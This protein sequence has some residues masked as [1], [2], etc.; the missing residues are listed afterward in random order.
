MTDTISE[1]WAVELN[2]IDFAPYGQVIRLNGVSE[3][4]TESSGHN[5]SGV[6]TKDPMLD[7]QGS[8]GYTLAASAPCVT[9]VMERHH[10][11]KEALFT[12]REPILL[13]VAPGHPDA[14]APKA[15][16]IRAVII[17]QGDLVILDKGTW[18]DACHGLG[19]DAPYYW[20]A[21]CDPKIVD[22]WVAI[23]GGPVRL[24]FE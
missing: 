23:E 21:V 17:R 5:W 6:F 24:N 3:A 14:A 1:V 19:V 13:A 10:H 16:D 22:P 4:V 7:G 20:H 12:S 8:L 9:T 2:E 11:T 15:R 18:H